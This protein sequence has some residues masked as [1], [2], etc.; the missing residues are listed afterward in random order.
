MEVQNRAAAT[1]V[2]Q[3]VP[4]GPV[5]KKSETIW[6]D[7]P[8]APWGPLRLLHRPA[9]GAA[10]G[11]PVLFL[12][13]AL[14][15]AAQFDLP[16]DGMSWMAHVAARGRDAWALDLPGHGA[17]RLVEFDAPAEAGIPLPRA[18][19]TPPAVEAALDRIGRRAVLVGHSW[20]GTV[21][22]LGAMAAP[23][24][25]LALT[26][27]APPYLPD[28]PDRDVP[29]GS[30]RDLSLDTIRRRWDMEIP[31]E[32]KASFRDPAVLDAYLAALADPVRLGADSSPGDLSRSTVRFPAG[33][34]ADF[35]GIVS[36]KPTYDPDA[37]R[38]PTLLVRGGDDPVAVEDDQRQFFYLIGAAEKRYVTLPRGTHFLPLERWAPQLFETVDEFIEEFE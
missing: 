38:P 29:H 13:G 5:M 34:F 18:W 28:L 37:I 4:I 23:E 1:V 6:L 19:D 10:T 31:T 2:P 7:V 26:L 33:P 12:H 8:E 32:D 36:G 9:E 27:I 16:V 25:V 14:S 11:A 21:A 35:A 15:A 3:W 22:A 20:G 17:S 30:W 24:R